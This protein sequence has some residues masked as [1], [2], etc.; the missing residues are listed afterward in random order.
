MAYSSK[1]PASG[2]YQLR[3]AAG[4]YWLLNM[5]QPGFPYKQPVVINE[6][7]AFIW[8]NLADGLSV[9]CIAEKLGKEYNIPEEEAHQDIMQFMNQLEG[10]R[11]SCKG[12]TEGQHN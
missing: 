8:Q 2:R 6:A 12:L 3:K 4:R 9:T 5:E 7:G 1:N 11:I 10:Q